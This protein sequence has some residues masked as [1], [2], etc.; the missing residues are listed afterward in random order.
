M[1]ILVKSFAVAAALTLG[2][3][4][5]A[6]VVAGPSIGGYDTFTDTNTG[7]H[8]VKMDSF[9]NQSHN[10]MASLVSA[11]GFTVAEWDDVDG[12]L[13]TLP[14]PDAATWDSYA[15]IMG[16]APVRNLIW[17]SFAPV[18]TDGRVD[19]AFAFRGDTSWT[20]FNA[21]WPADTIPSEG[22]DLADMNIWAYVAGDGRV[23]EPATW[24]MMIAGFGLVGFAA[25]RR[26]AA[27]A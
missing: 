24:A 20:A 17:G 9:F 2:G 8:W 16:R 6:A 18:K 4:A 21:D 3:A 19:W 1:H 13:S 7:W 15:A 14:L 12:L 27:I 5:S 23:P 11:A 22:T 25:R 26:T 10:S